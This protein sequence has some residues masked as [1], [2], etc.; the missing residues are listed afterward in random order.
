MN[1]MVPIG[2]GGHVYEVLCHS[3]SIEI[4]HAKLMTIK[5]ES[6]TD[7]RKGFKIFCFWG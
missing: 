6:L 5:K 4:N 7:F 1:L 2:L 3:V